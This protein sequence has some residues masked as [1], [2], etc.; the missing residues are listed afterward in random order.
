M[1]GRLRKVP[2]SEMYKEGR[3]GFTAWLQE[4][5]DVLNDAVG[6][7]LSGIRNERSAS[8]EIVARDS[9]G[10]TVVV[11][12]EPGE[13]G[14][15]GLGHLISSLAS[16]QARAGIWI[17]TD[18]R[19]EHVA[20][21]S[22]LNETSQANFYLLKVEAFRID[23]SPPAPLMTLVSGPASE[24]NQVNTAPAPSRPSFAPA[25]KPAPELAASASPAPEPATS[26]PPAEE[27][28]RPGAPEGSAA[29]KAPGGRDT[30]GLVL[31]QFWS[32]LLGKARERTRI[33]AGVEPRRE[34]VIGTGTGITGLEYNYV[35]G[36][37]EAGVELRIDRGEDDGSENG[38]I[39]NALRTTEDAIVYNFG[40]P[41]KWEQDENSEARRIKH[42]VKIGGYRDEERWPEIQDAMITA[43]IRLE[44]SLRPYVSRLQI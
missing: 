40:G 42:Y 18:S 22:W 24:S 10:G 23:N 29:E 7:S 36:E 9:S 35:V 1:I 38:T 12:N 26:A 37:H 21:V 8:A 19:P 3:A 11:E 39:L 4:N 25:P 34:P 43:M 28:E 20:A 17:V 33:H 30:T 6:I 32:E 31:Y 15:G 13:S 5:L 14:D 16:V 2:V 27:P 41:L 44:K